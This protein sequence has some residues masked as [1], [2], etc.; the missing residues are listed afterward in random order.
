ME[1]RYDESVTRRP[2]TSKIRVAAAQETRTAIL[3]AAL[4]LFAE[5]G[6][7]RTSVAA[8]AERAGVAVN[9]VYTSVG[10]KP[11]LVRALT[12]CGAADMVVHEVLD[13][14][15][16]LTDGREILRATA[17][18]T[19]EVTRRQAAILA[20]LL[21]NRTSDPAVAEA[22]ALAVR[23]YR[24]NLGR[25]ADR[26]AELAVLRD[27]VDRTKAEQV[28]WFHFGTSAWTVVHELGWTWEE[29]ATW[30]STQA[31]HALLH[32]DHP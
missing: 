14:V 13:E 15:S 1:S 28:L 20:V 7:T 5:R 9:T 16:R 21:D 18:G 23:R 2:Y 24:D 32:P 25:I 10:G 27:D 31:T 6:Y 29:A 26:L 12:E 4:A 30:L 19:G 11:A 3:D 8:V 22:A 17:R